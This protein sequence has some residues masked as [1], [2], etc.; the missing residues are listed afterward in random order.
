MTTPANAASSPSTK[1][2]SRRARAACLP[3]CPEPPTRCYASGTCER[4]S[5]R[6]APP[7]AVTLRLDEQPPGAVLAAGV[8]HLSVLDDVA[9]RRDLVH[10]VNSS[11][12]AATGAR[13]DG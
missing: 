8:D 3:G 11:L 1:P 6:R 4:S 2:T 9:N 7:R 12:A 13:M 10:K 5:V